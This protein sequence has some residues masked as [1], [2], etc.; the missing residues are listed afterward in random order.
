M[1]RLFRKIFP[2]NTWRE[3]FLKQVLTES[4]KKVLTEALGAV[5]KL[6]VNSFLA[7]LDFPFGRILEDVLK[8]ICGGILRDFFE[9]WTRR[10]ISWIIAREA[11]DDSSL[12]NSRMIYRITFFKIF[13]RYIWRNLGM[14]RCFKIKI[15]ERDFGRLL[16]GILEA[17]FRGILDRISNWVIIEISDVILGSILKAF[18]GTIYRK[19]FGR[20]SGCFEILYERFHWTIF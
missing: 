2:K 15:F 9:W 8:E 3:E 11:C 7:I 14:D 5:H 1:E 12:R 20:T 4:S 17:R 16:G 6:H 18:F 13:W 19:I 10:E